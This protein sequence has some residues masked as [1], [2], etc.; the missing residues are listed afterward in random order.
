M[1]VRPTMRDIARAA[2]VPVSA[3]PLVLANKPGVS[4]ARRARIQDAVAALGYQ[5]PTGPPR[6]S[7][8]HRLG[9]VIEARGIPI[10]SDFYYGHILV[11][12]EAEAKRL[13][14][15]VWLHTFDPELE[16][17]EDVARSARDEVDG[18]LIVSGGDMT[19]A[20]IAHL[21]R[22]GLPTV[23][24]DNF[25]VDHAVHAVVADNFGAGAIATR[26]LLDLGHRR[27]AMVAGARTYRKFTQ[28]LNG[29]L[30]ALA[31]AG[32]TP[33]PA[34]LPPPPLGEERPGEPRPGEWQVRQILALP[35]EQRPTALV[36][37]NDRLASRALAFLH[38]AGV[39]VPHEMSVVG[40]GNADEASS[41][42]P[43]LTTVSV[44]RR[45]MGIQ[46]VQRLVD[47]LRGTAPPPY[48]TVLYTHLVER[49]SAGPPPSA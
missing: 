17:I 9:L 38:R 27:I 25:L 19:D 47:L 43:P 40:I 42:I 41:T 24:V 44:P 48:K 31:E 35:P 49:E 12:I 45:E 34:W 20:R 14:L 32:I 18:L 13:G 2:G 22:T 8:R 3:V 1:G 16:A 7:R 26:H 23:L 6:L 37:T 4:P 21:E 46:G 28:R 30:D 5:R 36:M 29:Y 10:F 15:S 39:R 11:G 33:D